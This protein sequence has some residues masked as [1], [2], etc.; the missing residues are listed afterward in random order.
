MDRVTEYQRNSKIILAALLCVSCGSQ[1]D[2]ERENRASIAAKSEF[3]LTVNQI[4]EYR[5]EALKGSDASL[6]SLIDYYMIFEARP[7]GDKDLLFWLK[8]GADQGIKV[9]AI[10]YLTFVDIKSGKCEDISNV[11]NVNISINFDVLDG[12]GREN[13]FVADCLKRL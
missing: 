2:A 6:Q 11:L 4:S 9:N 12:I 7:V 3:F 5:D 1:S 10:N 8:L 13:K